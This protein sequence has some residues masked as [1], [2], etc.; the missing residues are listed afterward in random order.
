ML[1][2]LT[3]PPEADVVNQMKLDAGI[4]HNELKIEIDIIEPLV[5]TTLSLLT[6]H[7]SLF[8]VSAS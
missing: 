5:V 1:I 4:A 6:V 8:R 3:T 2:W 7:G